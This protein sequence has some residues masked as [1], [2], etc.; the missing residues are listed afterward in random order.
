LTSNLAALFASTIKHISEPQQSPFFVEKKLAIS[1]GRVKD[2]SIVV[3][4]NL[5]HVGAVRTTLE[6]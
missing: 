6:V 1:I 4:V 3:H 2:G 5:V